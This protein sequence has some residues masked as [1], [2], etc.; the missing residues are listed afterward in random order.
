MA[1]GLVL[2]VLL[3]EMMA[4]GYAQIGTE[5]GRRI[6]S[7]D[8]LGVLYEPFGDLGYRQRP[9]KTERY[10]NGTRAVFN[11]MGYRGP[12]VN[13]EKPNGTYR[14]VLLGG[15]TTAGY[16]VNDDET[17]DAHARRMLP[18]RFPGVC[19][20]VVNLALGGYDSYQ[21][22]ER[23]RVDGTRLIPDLVVINSGLNDVRNAQFPNLTY[24]PDPRTLIWESVM[25]QMREEGKRGPS[26]WHLALHYSYLARMPGYALDLWRQRQGLHRIWV[27]EPDG[28]AVDYFET[29][30]VRTTELALEIGAA[31][32]L[33]T[34]PSALSTR[35]KSSD[36]PEKSYWIKDAGTTE[37]YRRR[38]G[39]RMREIAIRQRASGRRVIY[40]SHSLPPAQ[41]LDDAHLTSDGNRTVARNMEEAAIPFIRAAFPSAPTGE[42]SCPRL[43]TSE[44]AHP[45]RDA[46]QSR[47]C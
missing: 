46:G 4:R 37:K 18:E 14:V 32:I 8:P 30:V 47:A 41:F 3:A 35:N 23:M 40:V 22:Y 16:G 31:V 44:I 34:P 27:A 26:L 38:L 11:S 33:S 10:P 42:L 2:G 24:P 5:A 43:Q 9:G 45:A 21:D 36:P 7:R 19:F 6:A 28:S 1:L 29:N 39:T 13:F 20:E 17:I 25:Q 12:L 15:S